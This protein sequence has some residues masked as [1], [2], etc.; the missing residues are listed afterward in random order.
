MANSRGPRGEQAD[1]DRPDRG[2]GAHQVAALRAR[3][4]DCGRHP[5]EPG[6]SLPETGQVRSGVG[7]RGSGVE[8]Q[9]RGLLTRLVDF[10]LGFLTY[11][12]MLQFERNPCTPLTA[13]FR[14]E[15]AAPRCRLSTAET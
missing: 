1:S 15:S 4:P 14:R 10:L 5:E 8:G 6:P 12:G 3:Q 9:E 7:A 13:C 2:S 11:S